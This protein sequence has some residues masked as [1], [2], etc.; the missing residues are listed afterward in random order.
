LAHLWQALVDYHTQL[1]GRLPRTA[2][3]AATRYAERLLRR[4]EHSTFTRAYVAELDGQ[5]VGYVLG[6]VLD[7]HPD[8]FEQREAG[9]IAD[10]FVLP[11][12]RRRGIARRL[13]A[14]VNAWFA[15]QGMRI[16][17]WSVAAANVEGLRFWEA[18]GGQPIMVQMRVSL[19]EHTITHAA[20]TAEKDT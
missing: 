11:A 18:L 8:L 4:V 5:V 19:D 10:L 17:E 2:N 6:S 3:G 12:Y 15:E 13:V 7:L 14:A 1:D 16:V 9:F 20:T